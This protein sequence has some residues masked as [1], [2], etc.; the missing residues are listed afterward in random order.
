MPE[1]PEATVPDAPTVTEVVPGDRIV[2]VHF[3]APESDGG[4]PIT[5][6]TVRSNQGQSVDALDSP[7]EI[8]G[9]INGEPYTFAVTATNEVGDSEESAWSVEVRPRTVPGAPGFL[10]ASVADGETEVAFKAPGSDGGSPI[11]AYVVSATPEGS[12]SGEHLAEGPNSPLTVNGLTNGL[13]YRISIKARNEAGLS[14]PSTP[15][16]T[17]TPVEE[18]DENEP[19]K[20]FPDC[21]R[22]DLDKQINQAQLQSELEEAL[23]QPIQLATTRTDP[24]SVAGYLW[25]VPESVDREVVE[26]TLDEHVPDPNWGIPQR[27]RDYADVVRKV[28]ANPDVE[29]TEAE[30]Q[31]AIKGLLIRVHNQSG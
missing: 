31:T 22:F 17:V 5:S 14:G 12:S 3:D 6:Y 30:M 29:L 7:V 23:G 4:S 27:V 21:A 28:T 20:P 15:A 18:T 16:V 1:E 19:W 2:H 13:T 11:T 26:D 10:T 9:L 25:V 24:T 8:L